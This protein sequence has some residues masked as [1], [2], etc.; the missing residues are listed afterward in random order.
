[1]LEDSEAVA[2]VTT[3]D[4]EETLRSL[5][6]SQSTTVVALDADSETINQQSAEVSF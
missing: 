5:L 2:V 6:P 1:M 3:S 4:M